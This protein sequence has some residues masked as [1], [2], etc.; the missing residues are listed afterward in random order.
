ML[1]KLV[2][3]FLVPL[4]FAAAKEESL[5]VGM[6]SGYAPFVSLNEKGDYEGFDID[7]AQ[8]LSKR[9]GRKLVLKDLG[10]MPSLMLGLKQGQIDALIWAVSITEERKKNMEMIYYQGEQVAEMPLVFW[11]EI[12]GGI[13]TW[14]DLKGKPVCVEAGS[15]QESVLKKI[16]GIQLKYLDKAAD[17]VLE[18]KYGKSLATCLD[19]SLLLKLQRQ[20]PKLKIKMIPLPPEE[21][22]LGNGI[23]IASSNRELAA[24]V[25]AAVEAM[26]EEGKIAEFEKKWG[27]S[28]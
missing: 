3:S 6:T 22:S 8:E 9:L 23:C 28:P 17:A 15:Y 20:F 18:L 13:E 25:E 12:P 11:N 26:R 10:S 4:A 27:L 19:A 21:R 24:Q 14:E 2:I 16:E 7:L 1:K 5:T